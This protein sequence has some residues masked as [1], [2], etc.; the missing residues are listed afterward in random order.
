MDSVGIGVPDWVPHG[1]AGVARHIHTAI[2]SSPDVERW[3]EPAG[4]LLRLVPDMRMRPAWREFFKRQGGAERGGAFVRPARNPDGFGLSTWQGF[5]LVRDV[6]AGLP[7]HEREQEQA[8][9]LLFLTCARFFASDPRHPS[10]RVRSERQVKLE[11]EDFR[12]R[13][14]APRGRWSAPTRPR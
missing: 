5:G 11:V 4:V 12:A 1:V 7:D 14:Q 9:A 8:V 6:T 2:A 3:T 13:A 10:G